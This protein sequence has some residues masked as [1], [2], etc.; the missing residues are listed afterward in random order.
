MVPNKTKKIVIA[1]TG[2]PGTGKTTLAKELAKQLKFVYVEPFVWFREEIEEGYDDI[3]RTSIV[4]SRKMVKLVVKL[5]K[6]TSAVGHIIDSHMS[7]FLP[8][9]LVDLCIVTRCNLKTLKKRLEAK[10]YLEAKVRE[11]LDAEIF[12]ICL[13]EA[14]EKGHK[15]IV[16]DTSTKS[17]SSIAR[18]VVRKMSKK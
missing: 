18:N 7:H 12:E 5:I 1:V 6:E 17:P 4:D 8:I 16:V 13:T 11:N 15:V 14:L 10:G 2:T 9:K 3:R